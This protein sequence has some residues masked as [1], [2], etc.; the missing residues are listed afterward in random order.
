MARIPVV[1]L[2]RPVEVDDRLVGF[3]RVY[4]PE[5]PSTPVYRGVLYRGVG[6]VFTFL[7]GYYWQRRKLAGFLQGS[8]WR[9]TA[10]P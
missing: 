2:D 6:E 9:C 7:R 4:S 10:P 3:F 8:A 5:P 1:A